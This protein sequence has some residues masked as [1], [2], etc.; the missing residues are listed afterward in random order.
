MGSSAIRISGSL[1]SARAMAD[2]LLLAAGELGRKGVQAMGEPHPA[3]RLVGHL[4]LALEVDPEEPRQVGDVLE[5]RLAGDQPEVLEDDADRPPQVG[6][7]AAAGS[8]RRCG[9]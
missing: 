8:T 6:D 5:H 7:L 9:R 4:L 2:P 3:Q 1:I